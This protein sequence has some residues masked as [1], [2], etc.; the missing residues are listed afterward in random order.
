MALG[1]GLGLGLKDD[2]DKNNASSL[3]MSPD[4][5]IVPNLHAYKWVDLT[6]TFDENSLYWPAAVGTT[7]EGSFD[8]EVIYA[9][10][11]D[12]GYYYASNQFCT[13]EHGGTHIDSPI[14]FA[15]DRYTTEQLQLDKMNGPGIV[16]DITQQTSKDSDYLL[17]LEDVNAF[18]EKYGTIPSG[19][20]VMLRT[21]WGNY[22]GN[23]TKYFGFVDGLPKDATNLHFPSYGT[24]AARLLIEDRAVGVLGIDA[25][26]IDH[27]PSQSFLVHQLVFDQNIPALEN[28]ANLDQLPA[29]GSWIIAMPMKIGS[30]SGGP[31][32]IAALLPS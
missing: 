16:I 5:S 18:E 20:I 6:H 28:V 3:D 11:T 23:R 29:V 21:G 25:P 27:G 22:Y 9:D 31:A 30:G 4:M 32:R 12:N 13:P 7:E 8:M 24:D 26:S 10:D 14:H 2:R 1:L 19:S 17:S 15:R